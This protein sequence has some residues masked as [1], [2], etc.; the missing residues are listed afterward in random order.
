MASLQEKELS[1]PKA[2][3]DGRTRGRPN[4]QAAPKSLATTSSRSELDCLLPFWGDPLMGCFLLECSSFFFLC[5][6]KSTWP[7]CDRTERITLSV[8]RAS[9]VSC[10]ALGMAIRKCPRG[11]SDY[12]EQIYS[13]CLNY[14]QSCY[15]RQKYSFSHQAPKHLHNMAPQFLPHCFLSSLCHSTVSGFPG[16]VWKLPTWLWSHPVTGGTWSG[17]GVSTGNVALRPAACPGSHTA[18][19]MEEWNTQ[20]ALAFPF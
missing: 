2:Q 6:P 4:P 17:L 18:Y 19:R 8:C 20:R 16:Q 14:Y 7:P 12:L 10:A 5:M 1:C 9:H 3:S 15:G 11:S 13:G